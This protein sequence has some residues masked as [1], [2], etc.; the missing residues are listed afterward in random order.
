MTRILRVGLVSVMIW[1]LSGAPLA[2]YAASTIQGDIDIF[3]LDALAP[4]EV[5]LTGPLDVA[6]FQFSTQPYWQLVE[7]SELAIDFTVSFAAEPAAT[8]DDAEPQPFGEL[9]V[10][11]NGVLLTGVTLDRTDEGQRAFAAIGPEAFAAAGNN[12]HE[13]EHNGLS[14]PNSEKVLTYRQLAQIT[15]FSPTFASGKTRRGSHFV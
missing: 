8:S 11:L 5:V 10:S 1:A 7:G 14:A 3:I 6:R 9:R 4:G 15:V 2:T 13:L 12:L